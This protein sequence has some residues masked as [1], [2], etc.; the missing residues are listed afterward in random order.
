MPFAAIHF[1]W[2]W[3]L[4]ELFSLEGCFSSCG[5][6][7]FGNLSGL[8]ELVTYFQVVKI[9]SWKYKLKVARNEAGCASMTF[10]EFGAEIFTEDVEY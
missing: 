1:Q 10:S 7:F 2:V 6:S 9:I 3:D 4:V 5:S 8:E